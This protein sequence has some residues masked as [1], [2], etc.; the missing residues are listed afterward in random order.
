MKLE[1][2]EVEG[3]PAATVTWSFKNKDH[4]K[5]NMDNVKI[6]QGVNG[7]EDP[8]Y[9][10]TIN[11][12]NAQRKQTGMYKIVAVNEHG[13]DEDE[14]EFVIL[15]PPGPPI[16]PL[17]ISDV[18]K[19][20]CKVAWNPPLDDGGSPITGY[21]IEKQD[22]DTGKWTVCGRTD[23]DLTCN[24]EG[25][26]TGRKFRFRVRAHNEEGDSE[27]LD[28]PQDPTLIKDPFDPPGPPGLPEIID[29]SESFVKLKWAPPLRENGAPVTSY[30][31]EYRELGE[32]NW[33]VGPKVKA[34]KFP[35]GIVQEGLTPGKKYEFRVRAENKAG[36]GEP[37][38]HTNPHLMKARYS[39]PKIDRTNL[40]AKVVK[41]NQQVVIEVDVSG[42]PNPE[43]TWMVNGEVIKAEGP[44]KAA[45]G[46]LHTKLM[47]IPAKREYCGTYKIKAKNSVGEDEAEVTV[48]I[49]GKPGPPEGPLD[50]FDITNKSCKLKWKPPKDDGGSPIEYYEIE[51]LDPVSGMWIPCGTSPTCEAEVKPL[52]EGKEYKFR[53]RAVN[54]DGEGPDLPTLESIIAKNPFDPPSKPDPP[55]PMD[56]GPDFCD[57][58]WIPPKS[59][60]GSPITNYII[61]IRDKDKRAWKDINQTFNE[62][63]RNCKVDAPPLV[64]GN[65][66]EFRVIAVNKA[67]P[68]EPSEP[69]TTI[70]AWVRFAKPRIDRSTLNKKILH[71]EQLLRIDADYTGEPEPSITWMDPHGNLLKENERMTVD[72]G[73][74]HTYITIRKCQ[75]S[76]TG[77][78]R[79]TAK[80]D[81]G[82]DQADI[83]V[84]V[85]S[86]P[87]KPMGP[88]WVT[89]VTAS[90]C[91][92][93]WK[94]P[95]DDGGDPIKYYTVEKMDTEKGVWIPCGETVGKTPEFDVTGLHEGCTYMFRVR[96]VNNEGESEPLETDTAILA[97]NPFDP[98]GP[99]IRVQVL[100]WDKKWVK[101]CWEKPEYD[102][103][104]RILRYVIEKKE[105]FAGK[106]T[107]H[108]ETDTDECECKVTDLTEHCKYRFRVRAVNKVGPGAPSEPSE[109]VT[110]RTRN[111]PPVI[112]RNSIDDVRVKVGDS[113]KVDARIS[114]TPIPDTVWAKDKKSVKSTPTLNVVHED[115][116]AKML[117]SAA[118]RVD[119][120][121]YVITA[122]NKNGKDEAEIS[123]LVVGPPSPPI[124]PLRAEDIFSDR[125]TLK[126]KLPADDGGSP[127]THYTVE[128][129]DLDGGSWVPCGKSTTLDCLIEGLENMHEYLFRVKAVNSEGDSEPLEGT[130]P[131]LAKN[132][133]DPPGPPGKPE[134]KDWDWDHF[135]LK[136]AE[137][138]HDG[139][140]RI[141]G[142]VI[143]KRSV[144]DDLWLK[145]GEVKPKLEFGTAG[146]VE[147]G[148]SY[149]F[150]VRAV[151]AAGVGQPGPESDTFVCRYKKLKPKID[152]KAFFEMTVSVGDAIEYNVPIMGE[153]PP[154]VNWSKDGR[155]INE[156]ATK[157]IKTIDYHTSI[158][159]DES[160]RQDDGIYMITAVNIHG[161]DAAEVKVNVVG[162]P[163]PPEGPL[164]V[165]DVYANG[166]KLAWNPPKDDGGLPIECYV[167]EKY[168]VDTGI[169][170]EVGISQ[171]CT[172]KCDT[173]EEG[174]QY[175]FR[176][177]A[178]NAEG[179]S[180]YLQTLKPITAKD[181][182]TVPL[183]PSAPEVVDWSEKHMDLEWKEPLDDGGSAIFAYTIEKRSKTTMEWM[184]CVRQESIR[185]KTTATMLTEGEEYQFRVY[186]EN[187]AGLSEPS[188]PSRWKEARTRY[189]PP[190]IERKQFKDMT[191]T[192]GEMVKLEA[193][194]IGEPPADV[195]WYHYEE[196]LE[197]TTSKSL[198]INNVPY[199]TKAIMRSCKQSDAGEYTVLAK[200]SQGKDTA[201]IMLTVLDK[202][203]PPEDLQANDVHASGCTLK[204]KRPKFDGGSPIEY[205]QVEKFDVEAGTWMA[206]GRSTT[207][208]LEVKGL[209]HMKA[210]KFRVTAINEQGESYPC[211]GK[212]TIIAK[213]PFDVPGPP[214]DVSVFDYDADSATLKWSPPHYD[215]GSPITGYLIEKK[216]KYGEWERGHEVPGSQLKG[217]V[218]NL[219]EGSTYE[220][221]VRAINL[222]GPGE[223]SDIAG[224]VTCKAR[225]LP[226]RIDRASFLEVRCNAGETFSF[227]VN[228]AGEPAPDKRWFCNDEE[229][230]VS[231][232]VKITYSEH[233]TRYTV[234]KAC[235]K[236]TG[237]LMLTAENVNGRDSAEVQITVLDV[238]GVPMGP[239]I[240][241]NMTAKDCVLEWK[242][243]KDNGGMPINY[244]IV[245]KCDEDLGGRWQPAGET[246]GP[247][248]TYLVENLVENHRYKFRVRAVNKMGKSEPLETSGLYTAKN[249][250]EVMKLH[251][252][253]YIIQVP[254]NTFSIV[255][256][257]GAKQTR[258]A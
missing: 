110:C 129:M 91:H 49:R 244:Y 176:V 105:D 62:S 165:S 60:G 210:Y 224:P 194:I 257:I 112:D 229:V 55:V 161:K 154:D 173:L 85:L 135:E 26:E 111:A 253:M 32:E 104:S 140:S 122:T 151:N 21:S 27:Y 46:P 171:T 132:P 47:M 163:G 143:E 139:G 53:V 227:D 222:A 177:K 246:D 217:T 179:E 183:P 182:F 116:R 131:V 117:F 195:I 255:S 250:F 235:R 99:P 2:V 22:V 240:V 119:S 51:K 107:K 44:L 256:L 196:V 6:S 102:G 213:N 50:V 184:V 225:N 4:T 78:Y 258:Q 97:R 120:G 189:K 128:K 1:N 39:P 205:Y 16:G 37:S 59:D 206:C 66:Y 15:G 98:P 33:T 160:T 243:P 137:P 141:T 185:C 199:N 216:L 215:G 152:R 158:K 239:L 157:R 56:W 211:E 19:E 212:D 67:G 230:S 208:T 133:F 121:T 180:K 231:E 147:L 17:V 249:P 232:R 36:L 34:K 42:D 31:I 220:F 236:D 109:E 57:L 3:E 95:K 76:D 192:A 63:A 61:E 202:P 74:Y 18:H 25:L 68:S 242:P 83:D 155:S 162:R 45:H 138:K 166:C 233:N 80:N 209:I 30:T 72:Y 234:R 123:I 248:T 114:G 96:A 167:V 126:W 71:E 94:P 58:K 226:P 113:I 214:I 238:P 148:K 82:T 48:T 87:G 43:T 124:G 13:K 200:N 90:G 125:C 252:K 93:E 38:E 203:D 223:P 77:I 54:K 145:C 10:T 23:G 164:E 24:L 251:Y 73:D 150:R 88:I 175:E 65:Y 127:I 198:V 106:Y 191:V 169:W 134:L 40:D 108:Q 190:K 20:G 11:F 187:K 35:D 207:T 81:Q 84:V 149:I 159:I 92:L 201:T 172:I 168:D 89:D 130:D 178:V 8:E 193:N 218:L 181:P 221:R 228:V 204:W 115:Y 188:Q 86:V 103:G 70:R 254:I 29:W 241:K 156:S 170:S 118:K 174:K 69:S 14:V 219:T 75:R 5:W 79:C 237:I 186:A 9:Y 41:V 144:S 247:E 146:D 245:E 197:T 52:S 136:W 7:I 64:E 100:D 153:P 28:G 12:E 142:Y 101:L